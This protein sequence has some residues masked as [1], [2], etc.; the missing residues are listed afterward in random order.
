MLQD[1]TE[2]TR[3]EEA[4]AGYLAQLEASLTA[5]VRTVSQLV[6]LRDPYTS[7]HELR[8]ADLAA[9]IAGE[10][11]LDADVQRGLR[12]AG[13]LHD[14]G[15]IGVPVEILTKPSRLSDV[16]FALVQSHTT[17]GYEGVA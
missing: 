4:V 5:T 9:A 2:R 11:G 1:I 13:A 6:E 15:K 17:M 16:E 3:N 8:V 14:V 12:V 10:M 7:G